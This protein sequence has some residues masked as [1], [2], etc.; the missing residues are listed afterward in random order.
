M[1]LI[2]DKSAG[3]DNFYPLR[4][5]PQTGRR[6]RPFIIVDHISD[7]SMSSMDNWF[8]DPTNNVGSSNF[9]VSK[10][11]YIHLYVPIQHGP[12]T[13]G[14]TR[15]RFHAVQAQAVKNVG[16]NVNVNCYSVSI[17]HE[18]HKGDL[19]EEQF[20][21]SA[22]LHRFIKEEIY[23]IWGDVI[24]LNSYFVTGHNMIDPIRKPYCPGPLFPWSRLYAELAIADTMTLEDYE[25]RI[26]TVRS[27][28]QQKG[29]AFKTAQYILDQY[30]AAQ[31]GNEKAME[32]ILDFHIHA[33]SK[34]YV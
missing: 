9:G 6:Y 18:G 12:W 13:Q 32:I 21:A 15:D 33:K 16:P 8:R 22:W 26:R 25:Q 14:I 4:R 2:I 30:N 10:K 19:T 3:V 5:D 24:H 31:K 20:W 34:G 29:D 28:A 7:G 23:R 17:E 27:D 1:Y 11:G